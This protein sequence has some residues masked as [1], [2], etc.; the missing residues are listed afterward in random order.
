MAYL[1]RARPDCC[2]KCYEC[3]FKDRLPGFIT[4]CRGEWCFS[5]GTYEREDVKK[6]IK[7]AVENC[8]TECLKLKYI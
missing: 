5:Q 2:N 1:L 8:P 6:R 4:Q 7:N 3:E